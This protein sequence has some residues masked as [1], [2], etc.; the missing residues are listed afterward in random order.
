MGEPDREYMVRVR[1]LNVHVVEWGDP[2]N[3]AVLLLHG[4]SANAMDWHRL[5][6]SLADYYRVVSF[7]QRG[8]GL[9]DWPGRY[10]HRLLTGDLEGVVEATGLQKFALVGHSMGGAIAWAYTGR[11]PHN[12]RCLVLLDASPEPPGVH[13]PDEPTPQTPTGLTAPEEI[14]AW[15]TAQGWTKRI[16]RQDLGRWLTRYARPTPGGYLAAFDE[17]AYDRAYVSGRMW[18]SN[19]TDWRAISRIACPTLVVIGEDGLVGRELGRQLAR[20]LRHGALAVIPRAG[21]AVHL[22]NLPATLAAVRPFLA[23]HEPAAADHP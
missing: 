17:S 16:G 2:R 22:E 9:T 19:R 23:T 13:E 21:H 6:A 15:A 20:R 10:T 3:A 18:P 8:H 14:V 12:V 11:H 7:D 1:R 5:A 4:R